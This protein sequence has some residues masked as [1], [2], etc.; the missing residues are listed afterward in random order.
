[1]KATVASAWPLS[2]KAAMRMGG[3]VGVESGARR[4]AVAFGYFF[5]PASSERL[6]CLRPNSGGYFKLAFLL[7]KRMIS[8]P[9]ME[10][11]VKLE[12]D[13]Y[14]LGAWAHARRKQLIQ[15]LVGALAIGA[16]IGIYIWHKNST[17]TNAS[18]S[19]SK[20]VGTTN[21]A[22]YLKLADDYHGT[23]GAARALLVAGGMFFDA[24]KFKDAQ[25]QFEK[26]MREYADSPLAG[27]ASLG[28]AASLEAQ[29]KIA[30]AT[31]RYEDL[32]RHHSMDS[33]APQAKSALARLYL[34]QNKPEQ[35]LQYYRELA[36]NNNQDSWSA[37]AGIQAE[38][39]LQKYPNLRKPVAPPLASP[40]TPSP[41]T[42]PPAPTLPKK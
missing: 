1:M 21:V 31:S 16:V 25:D 14:R 5:R 28:V 42:P 8:H 38:E 41:A 19:L 17:E 18:E 23:G 12:A 2:K 10:N 39:L 13:M 15:V 6:A 7:G 40:A 37:E 22:P 26:F 29:G 27:Q 30:E 20:L 36:Q 4:R 33:T 11:D 34:A 3:T 24:G 35:A 32:V 9:Y